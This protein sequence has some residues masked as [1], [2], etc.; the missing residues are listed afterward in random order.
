MPR[1]GLRYEAKR[2]AHRKDS[3]RHVICYFFGAEYLIERETP[4][5]RAVKEYGDAIL[6]GADGCMQNAVPN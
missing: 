6:A 4:T 5:F 1:A 3:V 2:I